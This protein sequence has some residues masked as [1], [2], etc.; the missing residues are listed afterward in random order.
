MKKIIVI[1]KELNDKFKKIC[2]KNNITEKI[3][4]TIAIQDIIEKM[5]LYGISEN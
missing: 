1:D 3:M 5:E 2:V 4:I